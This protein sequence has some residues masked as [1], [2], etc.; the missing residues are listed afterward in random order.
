MSLALRLRG[1]ILFIW[2]FAGKYGWKKGIQGDFLNDR[3]GQETQ[4]GRG[5]RGLIAVVASGLLLRSDWDAGTAPADENAQPTNL[6]DTSTDPDGQGDRHPTVSLSLTQTDIRAGQT[7]LP[8]LSLAELRHLPAQCLPNDYDPQP[9][10]TRADGTRP[11]CS[12]QLAAWC[13]SFRG[14]DL[15]EG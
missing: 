7:S 3:L 14:A 8:D 6:D 2:R 4:V 5:G 1:D 15:G 9:G 11:G 13:F 10:L 12:A